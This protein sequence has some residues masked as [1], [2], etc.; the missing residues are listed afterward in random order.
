M[1]KYPEVNVIFRFTA[2]DLMLFLFSGDYEEVSTVLFWHGASQSSYPALS[3]EEETGARQ[4]T[5]RSRQTA[6]PRGPPA[7][8]T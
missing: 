8:W 7:A 3:T 6:G 5:L 2:R 4:A 1:E